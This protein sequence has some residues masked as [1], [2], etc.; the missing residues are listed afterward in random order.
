M[1]RILMLILLFLAPRAFCQYE[2]LFEATDSLTLAEGAPKIFW[3][4]WQ[5]KILQGRSK[6][7]IRG[8]EVIGDTMIVKRVGYH[9]GSQ[10]HD[11]NP[12]GDVGFDTLTYRGLWFKE[13]SRVILTKE[14]DTTENR[15]YRAVW[16]DEKSSRFPTFE[17]GDF[18]SGESIKDLP[19]GWQ[20]RPLILMSAY[21]DSLGE[22]HL[23][24]RQRTEKRE[25]V[26]HDKLYPKPTWPLEANISPI[27]GTFIS[28]AHNPQAMH[29]RHILKIWN[30]PSW[31][32]MAVYERWRY[33]PNDRSYELVDRIQ[34]QLM[35]GRNGLWQGNLLNMGGSGSP[36]FLNLNKMRLYDESGLV[37]LS[38]SK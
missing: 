21:Y 10:W 2:R 22:V 3:A 4:S 12:H 6:W 16:F 1:K 5:M 17:I 36:L 34:S 13:F 26:K 37:D 31:G 35:K 18:G 33:F 30:E 23:G 24:E 29:T 20:S 27:V 8:Q 15:E 32:A 9:A 25:Q 38:F 14:K 19:P 28:E 11:A 7:L